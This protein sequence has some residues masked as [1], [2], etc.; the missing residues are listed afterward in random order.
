M[1]GSNVESRLLSAKRLMPPD[2]VMDF[3]GADWDRVICLAKVPAE[4]VF[5]G[6]AIPA[7]ADGSAFY[8]YRCRSN[9][10]CFMAQDPAIGWYC[11]HHCSE[12]KKLQLARHGL[13]N[14]PWRES[15]FSVQQQ[16]AFEMCYKWIED[17]GEKIPKA[18]LESADN[19]GVTRAWAQKIMQHFVDVAGGAA[20]TAH[21]SLLAEDPARHSGIVHYM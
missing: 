6:G 14:T 16:T 17:N 8:F 11:W 15:A 7:V 2:E 9:A 18:L 3:V 4:A 12:K 13:N 1:A 21:I 5:A 10:A 19:N 20:W